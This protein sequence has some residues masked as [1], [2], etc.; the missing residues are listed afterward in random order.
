MSGDR[1]GDRAAGLLLTAA[2]WWDGTG[3]HLRPRARIAVRGGRITGVGEDAAAPPG[4]RVLDLGDRTLMPGLVDC[5]VHLAESPAGDP[6]DPVGRRVLTALRP[7]RELL[8][9]GFTTVR[10]LGC[11]LEE[12]VAVHLRDAVRAGLVPGPRMLVAPHLISA[13]GGH[14][15]RTPLARPYGAARIGPLADGA[16]ALV[17]RV[18]A[19]ARDGADWIKFAATG[20]LTSPTDRP[21]RPAYG[22]RETDAL[23]GAATDLGLPCAT[24][25]FS[26]EGVVRALRAGVRSVEHACLATPPVLDLIADHGAY[27]VPTLH[28]VEHFLDHLDDDAFWPPARRPTREK[29]ARHAAALRGHGRRVAAS[30]AA[31]AFGTDAGMFPHTDNWREFPALTGAGLTPHRVLRAATST[32]ADLLGRPDLGRIAAGAT[33]DLIALPGDPFEEIEALHRVDFVMQR[34]AVRRSL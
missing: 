6:G 30:R 12:P 28:A 31:V 34:G 16:D 1:T 9:R 21:D 13:T 24:H 2:R 33:A 19:D 15:D 22:Q 27:L 25:A 20:G 26:D 7:L 10:D 5:H 23:V 14:S 11:D 8:E 32:A 29:L 3:E 18:R 4:T 17:Q